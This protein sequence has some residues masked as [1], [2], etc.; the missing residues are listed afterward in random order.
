MRV[1]MTSP[2]SLVAARRRAGPGARTRAR[3]APARCR[4][5]RRRAVRRTAARTRRRVRRAERRVGS[6][7]VRSRR[8]RPGADDG[9]SHAPRRS[10]RIEPAPRAPARARGARPVPQHAHRVRRTDGRH[11]PRVGRTAA[12]VEPARAARRDGAAH[13]ARRRVRVRARDRG[14]RTGAATTSCCGT[15]SRST[16]F[17]QAEPDAVRPCRPCSSSAVTNRARDSPCCSTRGAD[18]DRDAVLWVGVHRARRPKELRARNV[19]RR[20]VARQH[21]RP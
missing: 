6:R 17:A 18:L 21:L 3:A 4:R 13:V 9:A 12:P 7:T 14:R 11:V 19:P 2:Y 16:R 8:S 10:A 15:A 5:A 20:R 1:V